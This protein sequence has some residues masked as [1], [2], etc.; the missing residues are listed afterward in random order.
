MPVS[1]ET[2]KRVALED[3]EGKWELHWGELRRKPSM[4]AEHNS[5][6]VE[7]G[8]ALR[9]QL[10]PRRYR[11]RINAGQVRRSSGRYYIPDVMVVPTE[12]EREQL[13]EPGRLEVYEHPLPLVV[14]IWSRS[15]GDYDIQEKLPEY[16]RRGD[17]EIWF[18]Q[19]YTRT[20]TASR[21]QPD[22]TYLEF[23]F[24]GGTIQPI[25]LPNVSID[26]DAIFDG[27][28]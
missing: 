6:M 11:L 7:L 10:D 8:Y 22:G 24:T 20:L 9:P 18:L 5:L 15:T 17:A 16:Q 21:R 12:L 19:P 27:P 4:T 3:P 1:D 14:E 25:A 13:G 23:V 26:L 28:R 2:Y